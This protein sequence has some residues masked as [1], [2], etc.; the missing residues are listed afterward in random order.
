MAR[1]HARRRG[2]HGSKKPFVKEKPDWVQ[3][4]PDEIEEI[5]VRLANA[6]NSAAKIGLIL[7]D[8]Y[9]VPSVK[10]VTGKSIGEILAAKKLQGKLPD[11]LRDLMKRAVKLE[12]H[13]KKNPK[14]L[15]N[16]RGLTLI[17]SKIRRLVKYYSR[18]GRLPAGWK[19]SLETAKLEIE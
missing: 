3:I 18:E 16:K 8:A 2:S 11:D 6:G 19:Y 14:D 7:R 4:E 9:G 12:E 15:H 17:E 1:M 10:L 13:I 5:I